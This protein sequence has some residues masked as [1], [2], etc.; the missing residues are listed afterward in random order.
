[1]LTGQ[2]ARQDRYRIRIAVTVLPATFG[3]VR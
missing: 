1:M 2:A 3:K